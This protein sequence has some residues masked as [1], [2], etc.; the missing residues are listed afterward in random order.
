MAAYGAAKQRIFAAQDASDWAV[1]NW[2]QPACRDLVQ[3]VAAQV[4]GFSSQVARWDDPGAPPAGAL[5]T[6]TAL[7]IR[8]PG[9]DAIHLPTAEIQL[10]GRHNL[11]NAAAA[12]LAAALVGATPDQLRHALASFGGL[13]HRMQAVGE[14]DGV[15]FFNDSKATNVSAVMGSLSGFPDRYVLVAGGRHKGAPYT[16]LRSVLAGRVR[17]L[18]LIG[19]AADQIATDLG[20]VAPAVRAD[21]L[22]DAVR[23]AFALAEPGEAVVLSPACS[24]YD[25]FD[26]YE[27]RGDAFAEAVA[28]LARRAP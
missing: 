7:E 12:A 15:R 19:E 3:G 2:D 22:A 8:L 21:T 9:R 18:V 20:D 4:T 27:A 5:V 14:V 11:E 1:I 17:A 24:S 16:P 10:V 6:E 28:Q 26:N 23:Q 25:M 13:P